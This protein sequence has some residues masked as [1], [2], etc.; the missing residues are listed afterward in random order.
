MRPL[1]GLGDGV[2]NL[3]YDRLNEF[4]FYGIS[5]IKKLESN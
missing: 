1:R 5:E 4:S 2:Q 3:Y